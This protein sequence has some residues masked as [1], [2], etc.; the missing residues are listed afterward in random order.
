MKNKFKGI[1]TLILVCVL[2]TACGSKSNKEVEEDMVSYETEDVTYDSS[3]STA[4]STTDTAI[5]EESANED[6]TTTGS[7]SGESAIKVEANRKIIRNVSLE[8]ETQ[9]FD[10]VVDTIEAEI[11]SLGGYAESIEMSD[12][13]SSTNRYCNIIARI[14]AAKLD[15]FVNKVNKTGN[16]VSKNMSAE[17]VTVNYVD[18]ESHV[19]VLKVEQKRLLELIEKA[20]DLDSII[21]LENR[22]SEIRYELESYESQLKTYD[23]L[24]EYSTVTVSI[25]E[26]IRYTSHVEKEST[27][28]QMKSGL[29]D[30][31]YDIKENFTDFIIW[32]TSNLPYFIFWGAIIVVGIVVIKKKIKKSNNQ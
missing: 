21:L 17:D 4:Q 14:P 8:L 32:I 30:T 11:T 12:L 20:V 7:D 6:K 25:Q 10:K 9:D 1:I 27:W 23:N 29:K 5:A 3:E 16:V 26:V 31:L 22:L 24:V 28:Q 19:K 13:L 2:F 18:M 15:S